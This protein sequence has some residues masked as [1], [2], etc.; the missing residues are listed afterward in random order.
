M[1]AL[2]VLGVHINASG[3]SIEYT[4]ARQVNAVTHTDSLPSNCHAKLLNLRAWAD[5]RACVPHVLMGPW[6][7]QL[8]ECAHAVR[9]RAAFKRTLD[10]VRKHMFGCTRDAE[11]PEGCFDRPLEQRPQFNTWSP[12][13]AFIYRTK[14][15]CDPRGFAETLFR[16]R[17]S[18]HAVRARLNLEK[19][20]L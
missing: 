13:A 14:Y 9:S 17:Q 19:T 12:A 20:L 18:K 1:F 4:S 11:L 16:R 10:H 8:F 6:L 3:T 5:A 2:T 7:A 15:I